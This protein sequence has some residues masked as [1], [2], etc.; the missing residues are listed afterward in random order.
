M[1]IPYI[2]NKDTVTEYTPSKETLELLGE[3][4]RKIRPEDYDWDSDLC[5]SLV[6]FC[7]RAICDNFK[8]FP[9]LELPCPDRNHLL[10]ILPL[11]LPLELVVPLIEVR[12]Q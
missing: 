3:A 7:V 10:E 1:R 6:T 8:D 5:P 9:L 4:N 11:D 2:I 12:Y